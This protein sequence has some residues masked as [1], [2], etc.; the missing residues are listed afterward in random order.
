MGSPAATPQDSIER[1]QN[2]ASLSLSELPLAYPPYLPSESFDQGDLCA[3]LHHGISGAFLSRAAGQILAY[4]RSTSLESIPLVVAREL[5]S[6]AGR[7]SDNF[8]VDV[9]SS[10]ATISELVPAT[11]NELWLCIRVSW[12]TVAYRPS[13]LSV[14]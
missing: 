11:A 6:T 5:Q 2:Q 14:C 13:L 1:N 4:L 7:V 9:D 12:M 8:I 10:G 3:C